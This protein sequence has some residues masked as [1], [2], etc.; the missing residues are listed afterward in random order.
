V[1]AE[2][3]L[4]RG[5]AISTTP[6]LYILMQA[7]LCSSPLQTTC[8]HCV[9]GGKRTGVSSTRRVS[10]GLWAYYKESS[11]EEVVES[12]DKSIKLP[13][14]KPGV[15]EHFIGQP[16]T[17]VILVLLFISAGTRPYPP[18]SRDSQFR[19]AVFKRTRGLRYLEVN[20]QPCPLCPRDSALTTEQHF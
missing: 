3:R 9:T 12:Q 1:L 11:D 2:P 10:R 5:T 17:E 15:V 13:H 19:R 14:V 8:C 16:Y 4:K 7:R 18:P 20:A 6:Y